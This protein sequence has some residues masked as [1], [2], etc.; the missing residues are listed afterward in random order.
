MRILLSKTDPKGDNKL[1]LFICT[2][3]LASSFNISIKTIFNIPGSSWQLIS[4]LFELLIIGALIIAMPT[5]LFREAGKLII[6]ELIFGGLYL[7]SFLM[8]NAANAL[9]IN[10]G[11]WTLA[12]CIP[13]GIAGIAVYDKEI[14]FNSLRIASYI[15]YPVLCV[16]LL[17]MRTVGS[18]SMSVSY[19][20]IFPVLF[21]L[22]DFFEKKKPIMLIFAIIGSALILVFGAR[23]PLL[24][25]AVYIAAKL[26]FER[27]AG[28]KNRI[29]TMA[30]R[31]VVILAILLVIFNWEAILKIAEEF[32]YRNGISSYSL[33]R[34]INGQFAETAGRDELWNY[35]FGLTKQHPIIGF[36]VLGGWIGSGEGP[37]NMLLEYILAFGYIAGGIVSIISIILFF[38]SFKQ[39]GTI[40][41]E[42]ALILASYNFTMYLVSGDWLEKPMFFLFAYIALFSVGRK[43]EIYNRIEEGA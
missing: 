37:H 24:C 18:Y 6:S 32:L 22:Y 12:V 4:L 36:G 30:L 39:D 17:S 33:R 3:I 42:I 35:Y 10:T 43:K 31:L 15:E 40:E 25:I 20:L 2:Y 5:I 38:R 41:S 11:F 14:L 21:F 7:F 29:R 16:A 26:L 27:A 19:V 23:G 34:L 1:S 8:G 9:L 28:N 13:L